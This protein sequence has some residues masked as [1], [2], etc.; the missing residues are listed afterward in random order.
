MLFLHC[1]ATGTPTPTY[2]WT[3]DGQDIDMSP[4]E[5]SLLS[6]GTLR[7]QRVQLKDAGDY[8]CTASNLLGSPKS[9]VQTVTVHGKMHK[10]Q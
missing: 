3:L 4:S 2:G 1:S 10:L 6:N 9:A 7:I 5:Y 8:T